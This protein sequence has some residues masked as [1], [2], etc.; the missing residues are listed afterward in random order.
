MIRTSKGV[1]MLVLT[2]KLQETI[3][4]GDNVTIHI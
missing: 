3:K 2:R 1:A 4:I